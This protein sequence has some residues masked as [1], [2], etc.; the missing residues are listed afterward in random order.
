MKIKVNGVG[1][2]PH[3]DRSM[4][5]YFDRKLTDE[6]MRELHESL[7]VS[8]QGGVPNGYTVWNYLTS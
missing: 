7:D 5:F 8:I 3:D 6:E 2:N 1:R 4:I